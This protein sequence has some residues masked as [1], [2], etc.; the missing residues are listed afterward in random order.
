MA[1]IITTISMNAEAVGVPL[2]GIDEA[3]DEGRLCLPGGLRLR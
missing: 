1:A 2:L 3:V